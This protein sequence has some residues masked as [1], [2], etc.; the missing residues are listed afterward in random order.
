MQTAMVLTC[1]KP[2]Q[3]D[4]VPKGPNRLRRYG[5]VREGR[6]GSTLERGMRVEKRP[7]Y[8]LEKYGLT[9]AADK[10]RIISFSRGQG[11]GGERFD[12]LGFEFRWDKDRAG[13]P[14][15]TRRTSRK[16]LRN[17]IVNFTV[18]CK[19][20]RNVRVGALFPRLNRKLLGYYNYYGVRGNIEGL[21]EFY[22]RAME[23][24]QK[25]LNRRSQRRSMNWQGFNDLLKHFEVPRPRITEKPRTRTSGGEWQ[26][27]STL[28]EASRA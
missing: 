7:E 21:S 3:P 10:T 13:K 11:R 16:K 18:W 8:R 6:P 23:I 2:T 25:W 28:L 26:R 22:G 19:Q 9:L 20:N 12:F 17:S 14:H 5:E 1:Q 15:V 27:V 24:L 4:R